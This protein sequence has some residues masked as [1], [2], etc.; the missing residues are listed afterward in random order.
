MNAQA[1]VLFVPVKDSREKLVKFL[2]TTAKSYLLSLAE[3]W[4][5][6]MKTYYPN[7]TVTSA[8]TRWGSCSGNDSLHF[9]F[10]LIFAPQEVIEYVVVHELC[11]TFH[12]DHSDKFW[13]LVK[14]HIPDYEQKLAFLTSH[15]WFMQLF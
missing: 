14:K 6:R 15:S 1:G 4:A 8:R 10:R 11:H 5:K 3:T 9:S 2:K 7:L 12:K 13:K